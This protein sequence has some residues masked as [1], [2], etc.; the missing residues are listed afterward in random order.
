MGMVANY[1]NGYPFK[2]SDWGSVG[3]PIVRIAQ[4]NDALAT[5]DYF[6]DPL[7]SQ[8]RINSRDLLFS[9]SATL[10]ALIWQRGPAFLNQHIYKVVPRNDNDI[11]FLHH[12]LN[13]LVEPLAN[14]SHGTT[15]KHITRRDMLPFPITIP[16]AAEQARI[17][18]VLDTVDEAI[19]KTEA[20]I[21]KLKHVRAGLLH[22]LLT[23]GL[24]E[25]GQIRD[26]IAHPDKFQDSPLGRIPRAWE[27]TVVAKLGDLV[28]GTTPPSFDHSAWGTGLPFVTPSEVSDD[29]EVLTPV[30]ALSDVGRRYTRALPRGSVLVVCIGSTLGKVAVAP[31]DCAT[32][33]QINTIICAKQHTSL[34]I[35]AVVRQHIRQLHRWAGL[36]AVPIV[37]KSQFGR[38]CVPVATAEEQHSIT[39]ILLGQNERIRN[40]QAVAEK[41]RLL[42]FGLLTDLLTGHVRVPEDV[43]II[44]ERHKGE[45]QES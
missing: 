12:L 11:R 36:Q 20:V 37:N 30:R 2:P 42:K 40:E 43:E 6:A 26:P 45:H 34:Y 24:D 29:G 41:L 10:M 5:I 39:A 19:A 31:W 14:Q 21:A 28:T 25:N 8:Y 13:G 18:L 32:N 7:P 16:L 38:M 17:A 3:L 23:R 33:Q 44:T 4:M 9:W 27:T 22:D 1:I 35:A 15:M